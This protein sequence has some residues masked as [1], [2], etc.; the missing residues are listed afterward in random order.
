VNRAS[1]YKF[2]IKPFDRHD[3]ELTVQR[4]IESFEDQQKHDN[5]V[6]NL[7]RELE[8]STLKIRQLEEQLQQLRAQLQQA[9]Q[10]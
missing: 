10:A 1:I 3:F 5:H 2:I 9:G 7:G 8:A 6:R 4:A